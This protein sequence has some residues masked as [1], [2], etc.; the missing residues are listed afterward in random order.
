M[1]RVLSVSVDGLVG[2]LVL[3]IAFRTACVLIPG[4]RFMAFAYP[5]GWVLASSSAEFVG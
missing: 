4:F 5:L 2:L 3:I 1:A